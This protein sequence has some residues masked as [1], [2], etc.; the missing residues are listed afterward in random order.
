M[1]VERGFP[2]FANNQR[3]SQKI[4]MIDA[5]GTKVQGVILDKNIEALKD[6]LKM[7]ETYCI[8]N[9]VVWKTPNQHRLIDN[10]YTWF[11]Y[12]Q[13]SIK[14]IASEPISIRDQKYDF[15]PLAKIQHH[16]SSNES[17]DVLFAVLHVAPARRTKQA[18]VQDIIIIDY[19][20][21]PRPLTL[22]DQFIN[23]EG[24]IFTALA[25]AYP[26][27]IGI[28]MRVGSQH[29]IKVQTQDCSTFIFNPALPEAKNLQ[30]WCVKHSPAIQKL[31]ATEIDPLGMLRS[32]ILQ[33]KHIVKINRL[34]TSVQTD[35]LHWVQ[36]ICKVT[37]FKQIFHYMSCST[38]IQSIDTYVDISFWCNFCRARVHPIPRCNFEVQLS[39]STGI[40]IASVRGRQV[41]TIFGVTAKYL[42]EN[43]KESFSF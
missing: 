10:D 25:G 22:W 1:V 28:R 16:A 7:Y 26:V 15:V 36:T 24:E 27:V 4:V 35:E 40:L 32:S 42:K 30:A 9:A 19:G 18:W 20:M 38:C 31:A 13:T 34:P 23:H 12:A 6:T 8:S 39:D 37:D 17:I 21:E 41:E 11:L 5:E 43:T 29:G 33:R 3:L 2:R 14:Q